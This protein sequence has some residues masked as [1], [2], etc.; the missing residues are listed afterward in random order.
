MGDEKLV[1]VMYIHIYVC[2][3][4]YIYYAIS[5]TISKFKT[6]FINSS[7]GGQQPGSFS[8]FTSCLWPD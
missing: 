2:I 1:A 8:E 3:Y 4:I 6:G 5:Y 7:F